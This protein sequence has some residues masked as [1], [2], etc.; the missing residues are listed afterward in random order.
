VLENRSR[1]VLG[2][3]GPA[4]QN[5]APPPVRV[6]IASIAAHFFLPERQPE[7]YLFNMSSLNRLDSGALLLATVVMCRWVLCGR[8]LNRLDSGA[9]LL[10]QQERRQAEGRSR[11]NGLDS[12]ALLLA[13]AACGT[14]WRYVEMSQSPRQRRTSSYPAVINRR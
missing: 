14:P 2:S 10:A 9:L 3:L 11:L 1:C 12:G 13:T 5:P 7:R 4:A 8:R 6:S